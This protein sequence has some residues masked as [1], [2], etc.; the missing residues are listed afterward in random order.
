[1]LTRN[2]GSRPRTRTELSRKKP[3]TERA[4]TRTWN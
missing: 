1:M 3:R 2:Q 4:K